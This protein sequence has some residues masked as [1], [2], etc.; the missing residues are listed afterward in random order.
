LSLALL[1]LGML[2][3]FLD[4][5]YKTHVWRLYTTFEPLSPMSWGAWILLLV[6]PALVANLLLGL[7]GPL[8]L[9]SPALGKL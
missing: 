6:Y 4:L 7:P 2:A 1:T 5:E 8:R 3:L 9:L